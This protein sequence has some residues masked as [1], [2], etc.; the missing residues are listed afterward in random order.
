MYIYVENHHAELVIGSTSLLLMFS[1]NSF[2]LITV[3][4]LIILVLF[5]KDY[6]RN[7]LPSAETQHQTPK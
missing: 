7:T 1:L 3:C 6:S 4:I 2:Q 5:S